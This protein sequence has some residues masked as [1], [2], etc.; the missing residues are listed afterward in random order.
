VDTKIQIR[1]FVRETFLKNS[2]TKNLTD[3]ISLVESG[4]IDSLGILKVLLFIE[5]T[6]GFKVDEQDVVPEYFENVNALAAYI[7]QHRSVS[8]KR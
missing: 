6:F 4:I 2:V 5:E 3:D 1:D 7:D 8:K